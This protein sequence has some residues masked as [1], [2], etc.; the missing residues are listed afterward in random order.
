MATNK[1]KR[2]LTAIMSADA[3]VAYGGD[4]PDDEKR[5]AVLKAHQ[6]TF[7]SLVKR[8]NGE[9]VG[10]TNT[11]LLIEYA[12]A[13]NAVQCAIDVHKAVNETNQKY[14]PGHQVYFRIGVHVGEVE[15]SGSYLTGDGIL[16]ALR[17]GAMADVGGLLVSGSVYDNIPNLRRQFE[18]REPIRDPQLPH[19]VRTY[20]VPGLPRLPPRLPPTLPRDAL[21]PA[22]VPG[23]TSTGRSTPGRRPS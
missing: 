10:R 21:R 15:S 22:S 4:R 1:V 19:A 6:D 12:S 20:A 2:R 7:Q 18:P 14:P 16:L 23:P 8:N 3:V 13:V 9:V 17:L 5:L 11:A